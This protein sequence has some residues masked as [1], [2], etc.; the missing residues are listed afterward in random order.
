[1]K[2]RPIQFLGV[3]YFFEA[4]F[5]RQDDLRQAYL[6]QREE[7]APTLKPDLATKPIH[8]YSPDKAF[9]KKAL[10]EARHALTD[11]RER[12]EQSP[13]PRRFHI[14]FDEHPCYLAAEQDTP[15]PPNFHFDPHLEDG[16][17]QEPH[18]FE[19]LLEPSSVAEQLSSIEAPV[20]YPADIFTVNEAPLSDRVLLKKYT[21]RKAQLNGTFDF[22]PTEGQVSL[23][24]EGKATLERLIQSVQRCEHD[25][26]DTSPA[27]TE[28]ESGLKVD[29]ATQQPN[30][31]CHQNSQPLTS[32]A[33][34]NW[35]QKSVSCPLT[36]ANLNDG[37][38]DT[39]RAEDTAEEPTEQQGNIDSQSHEA[40][41]QQYIETQALSLE[42]DYYQHSELLTPTSV[43]GGDDPP[44][45]T[46]VHVTPRSCVYLL[47]NKSDDTGTVQEAEEG[48]TGQREQ[49]DSQ[50]PLIDTEVLSEPSCS[51]ERQQFTIAS[52]VGA[53]SSEKSVLD[54]AIP[55]SSVDSNDEANVGD[56]EIVEVQDTVD[57]LAEQCKH[58]DSQNDEVSYDT[59]DIP[60]VDPDFE[61]QIAEPSIK[62]IPDKPSNVAVV[63]PRSA[64]PSRSMEVADAEVRPR[65]DDVFTFTDIFEDESAKGDSLD[66]TN[67]LQQK[68]TSP[69][70]LATRQHHDS[71]SRSGDPSPAKNKGPQN[72]TGLTITEDPSVTQGSLTSPQ[73]SNCVPRKTD[74][75]R[76]SDNPSP[77][78][79][80]T[81]SHYQRLIEGHSYSRRAAGTSQGQDTPSSHIIVRR[82]PQWGERASTVGEHGIFQ[83]ASV[84]SV[85]APERLVQPLSSLRRGSPPI[86]RSKYEENDHISPR[87]VEE[88]ESPPMDLSPKREWCKLPFVQ[89]QVVH[90]TVIDSGDHMLQ[91]DDPDRSAYMTD[92]LRHAESRPTYYDEYIRQ[93]VEAPD[94]TFRTN[95]LRC[96]V[97]KIHCRPNDVRQ[98]FECDLSYTTVP[99]QQTDEGHDLSYSASYWGQDVEERDLL[100][101]TIH[102]QDTGEDGLSHGQYPWGHD[103]EEH[104]LPRSAAPF[105]QTAEGRDLSHT[106]HSWQD[107]S[108]R[109]M[110]AR[111]TVEQAIPGANHFRQVPRAPNNGVNH[112]QQSPTERQTTYSIPSSR[113]TTDNPQFEHRS[114]RFLQT[115]EDHN[116]AY[117]ESRPRQTTKEHRSAQRIHCFPRTA[118]EPNT[119]YRLDQ[120][121]TRPQDLASYECADRF[122]GSGTYY[123]PVA[124]VSHIQ[125]TS[126]PPPALWSSCGNPAGME[127]HMFSQDIQ[128]IDEL[129]NDDPGNADSDFVEGEGPE[130]QPWTEAVLESGKFVTERGGR[131]MLDYMPERGYYSR[132]SLADNLHYSDDNAPKDDGTRCRAGLHEE[133]PSHD[134]DWSF[135]SPTSLN[136]VQSTAHSNRT[137]S[138]SFPLELR[139][140]SSGGSITLRPHAFKQN[141]HHSS[142]RGSP[143][144]SHPKY[145][146]QNHIASE[147]ENPG[148]SVYFG[149]QANGF[150]RC[151]ASYPSKTP[152]S[153]LSR[154]GH[155]QTKAARD[156][157][158]DAMTTVEA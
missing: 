69:Q 113:E 119:A 131:S 158:R 18:P 8:L 70:S 64:V 147:P 85:R 135:D 21:Y 83:R 139:G 82:G 137:S 110:P 115:T 55:F 111:R 65:S 157:K 149:R 57:G 124:P 29:T 30:H 48:H 43:V 13:K 109:T 58:S 51:Q 33:C 59:Q 25:P 141:A 90:K 80:F 12:I 76:K 121:R 81:R 122:N 97:E 36:D 86:K 72:N 84:R 120:N 24:A 146:T 87:I 125:G 89:P 154:L 66:P 42:A 20:Q 71:S 41:S 15:S 142:V 107:W 19:L 67:I 102:W 73:N 32:T 16:F 95:P 123:L 34:A 100:N 148:E 75:D 68:A 44:K 17:L 49:R 126:V 145:P 143:S 130:I 53:D 47:N 77:K 91:A 27:C 1:M 151:M 78:V 10:L 112:P 45:T 6:V 144:G 52:E 50:G 38:S 155:L 118:S 92:T 132:H 14:R 4:S 114:Y 74:G 93:S 106:A 46:S 54:L 9:M 3:D 56:V 103:A 134:A 116:P 101:S 37:A 128:C 22:T 40:S 60:S 156:N 63:Q 138:V 23:E 117:S 39:E 153:R 127:D 62:A 5:K 11:L 104:S 98:D 88:E 129:C 133:E 35:S 31:G 61:E 28:E 136:G 140:R 96:N 105:R 152:A 150:Q 94:F 26:F 108:Y 7:E 2:F 79:S 99:W